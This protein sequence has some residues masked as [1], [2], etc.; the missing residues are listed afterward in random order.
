MP[1]GGN[2]LKVSFWEPMLSKIS[3]RLAGWKRAFLSMG[4]RRTL[5]QSVLDV[6]PTNFLSLFQILAG[7]VNLIEKMRDFLWDGVEDDS[8]SHLVS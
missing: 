1:L 3:K 5:I 8:S 2:P 6:L 4:G 7:I